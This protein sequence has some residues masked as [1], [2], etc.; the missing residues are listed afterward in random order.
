MMVSKTGDSGSSYIEDASISNGILEE[1]QA[2]ETDLDAHLTITIST[3]SSRTETDT[4][5]E[6][7]TK[8]H[9]FNKITTSRIIVPV[10]KEPQKRS[11]L[12][13]ALNSCKTLKAELEQK[14]SALKS[15]R[16][17]AADVRAQRS[18][19]ISTHAEE[20][21]L[22]G[23]RENERKEKRKDTEAEQDKATTDLLK[24]RELY[25]KV[26]DEKKDVEKKL[27]EE[28]EKSVNFWM[29]WE[30]SEAENKKL[31]MTIGLLKVGSKETGEEHKKISKLLAEQKTK[32]EDLNCHVLTL[33]EESQAPE[34]QGTQ[35]AATHQQQ[36]A[37]TLDRLRRRYAAHAKLMYLSCLNES[38]RTMSV[39]PTSS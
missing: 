26:K 24:L 9:K 15:A 34:T 33:R 16:K 14:D 10:A 29:R 17:Q 28:Q 8:S 32:T 6:K 11:A 1:S 7:F 12:E 38:S 36:S 31:K 3:S 4:S 30:K 22:Q 13:D 25:E 35:T 18:M 21:S 23:I 19:M 2:Q 20:L 27:R 37:A 5:L 39:G